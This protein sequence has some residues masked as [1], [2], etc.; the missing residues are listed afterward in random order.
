MEGRLTPEEIQ[1]EI[2]RMEAEAAAAKEGLAAL[3]D[4]LSDARAM[5]EDVRRALGGEAN[6]QPSD[7]SVHES[8][9]A[10]GV[11]QEEAKAG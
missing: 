6:G 3:R 11:A 1:R 4:R 8:T 10:A 2:A 7:D 5:M 9:P